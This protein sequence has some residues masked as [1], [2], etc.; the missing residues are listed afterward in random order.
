MYWFVFAMRTSL[1]PEMT[2]GAFRAAVARIDPDVPVLDLTTMSTLV[3]ESLL[4][5]RAA[6]VLAAAFAFVSLLIAE[7][8]IYGVLAFQVSQSRREIGV[9]MALGAEPVQILRHFVGLGIRLT[10]T[11][12]ALGLAGAWIAGR[13]MAGLLFGTGPLYPP[14]LGG[15]GLVLGIVAVLACLLPSCSASRVPPAEALRS[16]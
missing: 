1:A 5:R 3:E 15:T 2:G 11:G 6:V 16:S 10:A 9:R 14:V 13:S 7:I 12:L 4:G 8:G